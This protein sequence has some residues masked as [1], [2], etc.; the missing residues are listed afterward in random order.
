MNRRGCRISVLCPPWYPWWPIMYIP[1][2]FRQFNEFSKDFLFANRY[3]SIANVKKVWDVWR[4]YWRRYWTCKWKMSF[5]K[6]RETENNMQVCFNILVLHRKLWYCIPKEVNLYCSM[7]RKT[8]QYS[9]SDRNWK[10]HQR[11]HLTF[12]FAKSQS[13][14]FWNT[15]RK[16]S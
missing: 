5:S 6:R 14:V 7:L 12:F 11:H 4:P 1:S 16:S 8:Q 3:G 9:F 15:L 10:Y 13:W 2:E